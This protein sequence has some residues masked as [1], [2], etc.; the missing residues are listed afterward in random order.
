MFG[1]QEKQ[2]APDVLF[3]ITRDNPLCNT[4]YPLTNDVFYPYQSTEDLMENVSELALYLHIPFCKTLCSFCEYT[5]FI[6]DIESERQYLKLLKEQ[7]N[8]YFD[9]HKTTVLYGLDIGG[10]T[11]SVLPESELE[12]LLS[13]VWNRLEPLEKPLDFEPSF[14]FNYHSI[15]SQ[16]AKILS[17]YGFRR[18]STGIQ[19]F[20]EGLL[21]KNNRLYS[22]LKEMEQTNAGLYDN[23]IEKINIDLMYGLKNQTFAMLEN[24]LKAI[25]I[26]NPEQ[27]TLY[28]TRYN[29]TTGDAAISREALYSQYSFLYEGLSKIGY[30]ARFGQNTFSRINDSG[31]SSYIRYRMEDGIS[32]KGFGISAQSMS[33]NGLSYNSLKSC[34]ERQ[35]PNISEISE[36]YNYRLPPEE[37]VAK[38]VSV[39]LYGGR[40]RE[41]AITRLLK[42]D[43]NSHFAQEFTFLEASKLL[44]KD[45]DFW[46]LTPEGFK[47]YGGVA[48]LFWSTRQKTLFLSS[49]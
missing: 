34:P 35:M 17:S 38:Y 13:F 29:Q 26:L 4:S 24:T 23:G 41:S 15:T 8:R 32:Y 10:G 40:F 28:E 42:E 2:F 7:F 1:S 47:H 27:V 36:E 31:C 18:L 25:E 16:K 30:N 48:A 37:V 6:A 33:P 20:D 22:S 14:E 43:A 49:N 45:G 9:T 5:R 11:P 44:E 21:S 39:S 46:A 12:D 3:E 19:V